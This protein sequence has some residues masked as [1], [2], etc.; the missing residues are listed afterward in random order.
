MIPTVRGNHYA[1]LRR[2]LHDH[3]GDIAIP[4][5]ESTE[6]LGTIGMIPRGAVD[7]HARTPSSGTALCQTRKV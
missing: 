5:T 7:P 6:T 1:V 3:L 2:R 4:R